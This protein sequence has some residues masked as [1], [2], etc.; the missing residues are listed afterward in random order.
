MNVFLVWHMIL[1]LC[2]PPEADYE[3]I[4]KHVARR[5]E[6]CSTWGLMIAQGLGTLVSIYDRM[7]GVKYVKINMEVYCDNSRN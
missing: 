1:L 3:Y 5:V 4:K 7:C 2:Y 6:W